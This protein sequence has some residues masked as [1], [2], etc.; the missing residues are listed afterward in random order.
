MRINK[1]IKIKVTTAHIR[2]SV[3]FLS[4]ILEKHKHS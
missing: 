2:I 3:E 4:K 1:L